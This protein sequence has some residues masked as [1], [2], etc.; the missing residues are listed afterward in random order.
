MSIS[1]CDATMH[2]YKT[3]LLGTIAKPTDE[4]CARRITIWS[5]MLKKAGNP[6]NYKR[7]GN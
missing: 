5:C 6:P 7:N 2:L 4:I 1:C 3:G